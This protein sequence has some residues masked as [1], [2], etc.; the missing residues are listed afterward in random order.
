MPVPNNGSVRLTHV[1]SGAASNVAPNPG[2]LPSLLDFTV[3]P[4]GTV[5]GS[6]P[7]QTCTGTT[8]FTG[9]LA[10]PTSVITT[11]RA[12][13]AGASEN[14]CIQA[15]LPTGTTTGQ[16]NTANAVFTFTATS[17]P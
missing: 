4:L 12:L 6:S 17:T 16:N 1:A 3:V 2:T 5:S 10:S 9:T 14:V 15:T 11:A 7:A 8:S 13:A